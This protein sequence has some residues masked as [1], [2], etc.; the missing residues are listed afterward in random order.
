MPITWNTESLRGELHNLAFVTMY[1]FYLLYKYLPPRY[2][3]YPLLALNE[4]QN[5]FIHGWGLEQID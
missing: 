5:C 2:L 4:F 1:G 3:P